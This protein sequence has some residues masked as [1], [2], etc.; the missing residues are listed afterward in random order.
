VVA[1]HF[2]DVSTLRPC[3]GVALSLVEG[4]DL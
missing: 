1:L 4:R 3:S 2:A